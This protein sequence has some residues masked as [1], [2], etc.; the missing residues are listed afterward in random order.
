M[1][2]GSQLAMGSKP[3]L[4]ICRV[5]PKQHVK[6]QPGPAHVS[7][8]D[9]LNSPCF[10]TREPYNITLLND[11]IGIIKAQHMIP[12]AAVQ[13]SGAVPEVYVHNGY[14]LGSLY[15]YPNFPASIGLDNH[16][17]ISGLHWQQ[18]IP[19][20]ATAMGTMN[21][22]DCTPDCSS[23]TYQTSPVEL[24]VSDPQQ[25]LVKVYKPNSAA[26]SVSQAFV[27]N[28]IY[29]KS[30]GGSP[31]A[32]LVGYTASLPPACSGTPSTT[33][34]TGQPGP[35]GSSG[36][37]ITSATTYQQGALVYFSIHYS[38]PN[39]IAQGF[40]F[41]GVKGSGWAEEQHPFT[42]PSYGIVGPDSIDYPFNVGC[43]TSQQYSS[44]VK[45]WIYGSG[46]VHSKPVVIHLTCTGQA[47]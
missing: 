5:L 40:G 43:G 3:T 2:T 9:A 24:Q 11:I 6:Q 37:T 26:Y 19:S 31:P 41:V 30:L 15:R 4:D 46:G 39:H 42:S 13:S 12:T 32:S 38:D 34:P 33:G 17:Y 29:V 1:S 16:D 45:A 35:T 47:G 10:H 20:R 25:C 18:V 44:Y 14:E 21:F 8:F 27:Y 23:G 36:L 7:F 28:K 22:D